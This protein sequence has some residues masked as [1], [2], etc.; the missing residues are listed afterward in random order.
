MEVGVA[1]ATRWNVPLKKNAVQWPFAQAVCWGT[2]TQRIAYSRVAVKP[3]WQCARMT[4]QTP[5]Q[6]GFEPLPG[7]ILLTEVCCSTVAYHTW[8]GL[9]KTRQEDA[10]W[11]HIAAETEMSCKHTGKHTWAKSDNCW[12]KTLALTAVVRLLNSYNSSQP[13]RHY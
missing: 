9:H 8:N 7:W 11:R 10:I 12:S 4:S 3:S 13:T 2:D 1:K 5:L 6:H